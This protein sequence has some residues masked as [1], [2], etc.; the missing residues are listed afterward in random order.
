MVRITERLADLA[1]GAFLTQAVVTAKT[2]LSEHFV[3]VELRS[4]RFRTA[5]WTPGCKV[6]LRTDRGMTMRTYTPFGWDPAEGTV[7]LVAYEHGTGPAA[8]WFDRVTPGDPCDLL[9]P[10]RS[11]DLSGAAPRLVFVGDETSV[12]LAAVL[13]QTR[14]DGVTYVLESTRPAEYTEVLAALGVTATVVP[15]TADRRGLLD[16]AG[17]GA[18]DLV[19]TGDAATV[20]PIRRAAR[21]WT[22]APGKVFGK[23]YWAEGRTGLD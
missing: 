22:P 20:G 21:D 19:V 17:T 10:R 8:R 11:I 16:A 9:G 13:R 5:S 15:K 3:R 7:S 23:A 1:S 12:G 2:A 14:P 6:Q 18:Y 4:D